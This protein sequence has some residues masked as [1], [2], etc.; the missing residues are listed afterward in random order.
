[1][2]P[3]EI[4]E[5]V[6]DI[7]YRIP[8]SPNEESSNCSGKAIRLKSLLKTHGYE[9]RYRICKFLWSDI[10]LPEKIATIPHND[11]S[12]HVFLEVLVGDRWITVDPAWDSPLKQ[13]FPTSEWSGEDA[14]IAVNPHGFFDYETSRQIMEDPNPEDIIQDLAINGDFYGAFNRWLEEIRG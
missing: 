12:T 2:T 8:L 13:I 14:P 11:E 6:R 1:M 10:A 9:S 7:P 3:K 4:F 5:S